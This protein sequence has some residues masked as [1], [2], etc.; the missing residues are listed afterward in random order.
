MNE[1][2]QVR[3]PA[4]VH[5][6]FEDE[7]VIVNLDSGDYYSLSDAGVAFWNCLLAGC[8]IVETLDVLMSSYAGEEGAIE[9][10]VGALIAELVRADLIVPGSSGQTSSPP[11]GKPTEAG[12]RPPFVAPILS[13]YSDMRDLL[14]IDPIHE[15]DET[16]WPRVK[17]ES[18]DPSAGQST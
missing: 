10:A 15:V 12:D 6:V 13:R 1:R 7:V 17:K 9:S 16:G 18:D 8:S 11:A 2:Y 4:V 14:L 5:E 3:T